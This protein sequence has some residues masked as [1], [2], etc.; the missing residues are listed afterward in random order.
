MRNDSSETFACAMLI[1]GVRQQKYSSLGC[2]LQ[3]T[4]IAPNNLGSS[5]QPLL[6][7]TYH[8]H[9]FFLKTIM[10]TIMTQLDDYF[11]FV[12]GLISC[13]LLSGP[14]SSYYEESVLSRLSIKIEAR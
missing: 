6:W 2:R 4:T 5:E 8:L 1:T 13:H 7:S 9:S 14:P 3:P 10:S 12:F 11:S